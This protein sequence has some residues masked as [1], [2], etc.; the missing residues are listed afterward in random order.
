V[1]SEVVIIELVMEVLEEESAC[2][3][4]YLKVK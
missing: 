3:W 1:G 2:S 4:E